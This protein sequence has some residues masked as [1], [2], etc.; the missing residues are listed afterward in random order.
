[1]TSNPLRELRFG[2]GCP[3]F[4]LCKVGP[5]LVRFLSFRSI[6]NKRA[7]ARRGA[8]R[9]KLTGGGDQRGLN[10]SNSFNRFMASCI[11]S[12]L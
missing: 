4:L 12:M 5:I 6:Q 11:R 7:P 10:V 3:R 9:G 2:L 1:M 8:T